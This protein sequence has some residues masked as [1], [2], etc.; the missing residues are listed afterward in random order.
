MPIAIATKFESVRIFASVLSEHNGFEQKNQA[1]MGKNF[2]HQILSKSLR[3]LQKKLYAPLIFLQLFQNE[4]K[5]L[6]NGEIFT[7]KLLWFEN[8]IDFAARFCSFLA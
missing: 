4:Q 6:M 8:K 2:L 1:R 7:K 5:K 3:F